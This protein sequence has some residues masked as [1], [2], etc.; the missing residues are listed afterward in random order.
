MIVY[1]QYLQPK[2]CASLRSNKCAHE[3]YVYLLA[4]F[5]LNYFGG[6]YDTLIS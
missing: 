2:L 5:L 1:I 4:A 3:A 6:H